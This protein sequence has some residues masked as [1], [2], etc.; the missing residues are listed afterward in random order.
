MSTKMFTIAMMGKIIKISK[1][2]NYPTL[3]I[4]TKMSSTT[5]A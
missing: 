2:I 5:K 1:G 3:K 4:S